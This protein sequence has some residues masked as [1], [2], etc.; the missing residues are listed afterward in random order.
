MSNARVARN[1]FFSAAQP[2][3]EAAPKL[4]ELLRD[5][6]SLAENSAPR[7]E[8]VTLEIVGG[9]YGINV[10]TGRADKPVGVVVVNVQ[11]K[12]DASGT[13]TGSF[14]IDWEW[15]E[16]STVRIRNIAG[17]SA[18]QKYNVTLGVFYS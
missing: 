5:L 14:A 10:M 2:W 16:N 6:K 12:P 7:I 8:Y 17:L 3:A 9:T 13:N 4:Q 15:R 18:S 11:Q 1:P